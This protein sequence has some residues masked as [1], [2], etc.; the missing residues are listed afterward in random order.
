MSEY[1]LC[2]GFGEKNDIAAA[3]HNFLRVGE[4]ILIEGK[5]EFKEGR[6]IQISKPDIQKLFFHGKQCLHYL[7]LGSQACFQHTINTKGSKSILLKGQKM[8]D[9][10]VV[11]II[12]EDEGR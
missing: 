11:S 9:Q 7:N 12:L 10:P 5:T 6:F 4:V 1:I 8:A 2:M 3:Y